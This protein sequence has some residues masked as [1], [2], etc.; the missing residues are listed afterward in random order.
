MLEKRDPQCTRIVSC[1]RFCSDW[2][3][4]IYGDSYTRFKRFEI[5]HMSA[6]ELHMSPPTRSP[7]DPKKPVVCG[8]WRLPHKG[9]NV[10]GQIKTLLRE[11]FEFKQ[12]RLKPPEPFDAAAFANAKAAFYRE[13]DL[14]LCLSSHE[15]NA[16]FVL[17]GLFCGLPLVSTNVGLADELADG[18]DAVVL[19]WRV[20]HADPGAVADAVRLCWTRRG[21]LKSSAAQYAS[22]WARHHH[23]PKLQEAVA[24]LI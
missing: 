10:I 14:M 11:E 2:F 19:D 4:R 13:C 21:Q 16:Y 1:A 7:R 3:E 12:M 23:V 17:D 6:L 8:D 15:G 9:A 24:S 5:P 20:A 18:V 22:R